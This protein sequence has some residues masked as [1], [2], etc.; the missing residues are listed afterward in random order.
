MCT[1]SSYCNTDF[2]YRIDKEVYLSMVEEEKNLR[3]SVTPLTANFN[4]CG[5]GVGFP[6]FFFLL[7]GALAQHRKP[8]NLF[9]WIENSE[10][11]LKV[12]YIS[13]K[14]NCLHDEGKFSGGFSV[15]EFW[16]PLP[17]V[18]EVVMAMA[19]QNS[20]ELHPPF[21]LFPNGKRYASPLRGLFYWSV[22]F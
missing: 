20:T 22:W 21:P 19:V 15:W 6:F 1:I 11:L 10:L 4:S 18:V 14:S 16:K 3:S 2:I 5:V 13:I 9:N 17:N 12:Q 7:L 8:W